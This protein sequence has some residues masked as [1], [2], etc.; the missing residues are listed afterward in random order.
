MSKIQ[1]KTIL[2]YYLTEKCVLMLKMQ[3]CLLI[4]ICHG[5]EWKKPKYPSLGDWFSYLQYIHTIEY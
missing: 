4:I 3:G 2:Q 1:L 5:K